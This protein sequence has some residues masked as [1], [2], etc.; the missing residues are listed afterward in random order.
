MVP[1]TDLSGPKFM[2]LTCQVGTPSPLLSQGSPSNCGLDFCLGG[3]L[4]LSPG[5]LPWRAPPWAFPPPKGHR[6]GLTPSAC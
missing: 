1:L 4:G 6:G 3:E 5:G 2:F